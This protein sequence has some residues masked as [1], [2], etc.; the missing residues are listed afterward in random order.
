MGSVSE[1]HCGE[2]ENTYLRLGNFSENHGVYKI[3]WKNMLEPEMLQVTL[4]YNSA[5]AF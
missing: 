5:N 4:Y 1:E 2:K 3:M